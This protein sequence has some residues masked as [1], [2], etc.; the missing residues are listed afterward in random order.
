MAERVSI[1]EALASAEGDET[2]LL[3]AHLR[4]LDEVMV[5]KGVDKLKE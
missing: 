3:S 4:V 2:R 5:K 1:A